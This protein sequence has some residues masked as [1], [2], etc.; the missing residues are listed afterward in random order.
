MFDNCTFIYFIMFVNRKL[1]V[2]VICYSLL[3]IFLGSLYC[4]Q[5]EPRSDCSKGD[6]LIRGHIVC[7]HEKI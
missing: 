7:L 3:L 2:T 6:S 4:K 5:Y 1:V